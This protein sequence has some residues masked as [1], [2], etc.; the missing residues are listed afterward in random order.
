[1]L[2]TNPGYVTYVEWRVDLNPTQSVFGSF[3]GALDALSKLDVWKIS[4][5]RS[6]IWIQHLVGTFPKIN[7]CYV[8]Y[9][10]KHYQTFL[11]YIQILIDY[12]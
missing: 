2:S 10:Y 4:K 7:F 3:L 9:Q 6:K 1:M 8:S 12:L 11:V 5:N